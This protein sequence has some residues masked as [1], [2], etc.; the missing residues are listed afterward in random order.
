MKLVNR[1]SVFFLASIGGVLLLFSV[2]LYA[3]ASH[4]LQEQFDHQLTTS[5]QTL[6][7]AIEV[8]PDDVKWEP[9]DHTVS[10]G[11][12]SDHNE[13]R[14]VVVDEAGLVVDQSPNLT[15]SP[16]DRAII[17][18]A[19]KERVDGKG[20]PLPADWRVLQYRLFA[21]AP[22]PIEL[23]D[24]L[25]RS[26]LIVTVALST[27]DLHATLNRLALALATLS[28]T[29]LLLAAVGG[30]WV[31]RRALQPL[32][33]MAQE[34][35]QIRP[36][37]PDRRLTVS[38]AGDELSELALAFNGLLDQLFSAFEREKRFAGDAAHQLRTPLTVLE[39]EIDVALRRSR[40]VAEYER[41]LGV[42]KNQVG[43]LKGIIESLLFLARS[44]G[45]QAGP[46]PTTVALEP[47]LVEYCDK[48]QRHPRWPDVAL[49][50]QTGIAVETV[51]VFLSQVLDNV[52]G[53]AM[54][55]SP[56]G[57]T[58]EVRLEKSRGEAVLSV[59]DEGIGVSPDEVEAIFRPFYR[60]TLA[61]KAGHAGTGLGLTIAARLLQTMRGR[62][63]CRS[64]AVGSTF[65]IYL[66]LAAETPD[67]PAPVRPAAP[68]PANVT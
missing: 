7:A 66:P 37:E 2:V 56:A 13:V 17:D 59:A 22:K 40:T 68:Q 23:R 31:G 50:L 9:S 46:A 33:D 8:E 12:E 44:E 19:R 5:L 21:T 54:K 39:G 28:P 38:P 16:E 51:P 43:D 26:E 61:R 60:T 55:Y 24:P 36:A 48:W 53:N 35:R 63:E 1:V 49:K 27:K 3:L 57:S 29:I 67:E 64:Q 41:T 47:W 52:L 14:W 4:Y 6:V 62:I 15:T 58:I 18:Y 11:D 42:L 32:E 30:R 20:P 34:V 10:L 45:D 65:V 25:E